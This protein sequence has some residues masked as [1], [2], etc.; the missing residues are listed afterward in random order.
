MQVKS[1]NEITPDYLIHDLSLAEF[2][3]KEIEI[4]EHEMPG[5]MGKNR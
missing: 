3:R 4:A 1:N 2:G 5:L